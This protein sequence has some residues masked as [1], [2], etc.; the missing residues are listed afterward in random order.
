M[1][2][3]DYPHYKSWFPHSIDKILEWA[4]L[5]P[6][7]RRK[8]FWENAT[9]ASSRPEA[10][11]MKLG[12]K[13]ALVTGAQQG[14]GRATALALAEEG[15]DVAVNWLDDRDAAESVARR[16]ARLAEGR[17]RFRPTCRG[18]TRS[19]RWSPRPGGNSGRST[20][21]STMPRFFRG[22]RFST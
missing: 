11:A 8:L 9:A 5:G 4:S 15:A 17:T 6:E 10:A 21:S 3:S 19:P 12:G 22:F 20:S 7:V 16:S 1:F 18:S 13:I 14:I 2:G